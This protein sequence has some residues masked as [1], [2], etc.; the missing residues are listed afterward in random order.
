MMSVAASF[1]SVMKPRFNI[2]Q[3]G[4]TVTTEGDACATW[5]L[6]THTNKYFAPNL[7]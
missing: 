7:R 1:P 2:D 6:H 5:N 3:R 4:E